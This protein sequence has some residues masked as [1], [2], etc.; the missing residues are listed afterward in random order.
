MT[1]L[2][3]LICVSVLALCLYGRKTP[4]IRGSLTVLLLAGGSF[5]FFGAML[6]LLI[7]LFPYL[8]WSLALAGCFALVVGLPTMHVGA[9]KAA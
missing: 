5:V 4:A 9:K 3:L 1:L 7:G 2:G 6:L 8:A